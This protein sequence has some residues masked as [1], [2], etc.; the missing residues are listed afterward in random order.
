MNGFES[1]AMPTRRHQFRPL[2]ARLGAGAC[3]GA[4]A[5][6]AR[7]GVISQDLERVLAQ[8][9]TQAEIAV[10]VRFEEPVDLEALSASDRRARDNRLMLA[11]K[12]RGSRSRAAL[13]PWLAAQGAVRIQDLWIINGIAA[14]L[15]ASAVRSL[16]TQ[17]GVARVEPDT[18]VQG[19]RPQRLP[20]RARPAAPRHRRGR[21]LMTM[22]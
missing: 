18:F 5:L 14:A 12:Q 6:F 19:G 17:D 20:P 13:E 22:R 15:P 2:A 10:I 8:R 16:A 21:H 1:A 11:L 3:L 7:A 4:V 9:G